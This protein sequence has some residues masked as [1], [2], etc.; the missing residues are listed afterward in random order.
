MSK[1]KKIHNQINKLFDGIKITEEIEPNEELA[2]EQV[3]SALLQSPKSDK[4]QKPKQV[5]QISSPR[6][7]PRT[8]VAIPELP[9]STNSSSSMSI[10][11]Q[12]GDIW[13]AI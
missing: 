8:R 1:N 13:Q 7:R 10:P 11:F 9:K 6:T 4:R 2:S 5:D 3:T 12:A